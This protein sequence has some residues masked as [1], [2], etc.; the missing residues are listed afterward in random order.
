MPPDYLDT[1][2]PTEFLRLSPPFFV[3]HPNPTHTFMKNTRLPLAVLACLV[4]ASAHAQT[5]VRDFT[6]AGLDFTYVNWD[7]QAT[8]TATGLE[9]AGTATASGGGG[10]GIA[11]TNLSG[12]DLLRIFV[13]TL[14]GNTVP[15]FNVILTSPGNLASGYTFSTSGLNSEYQS[16]TASILAPTFVGF[17]ADG[18]ADLANIT[19]F[20]LQGSFANADAL[21]LGFARIE[22]ASAIPEPSSFASVAAL[23]AL[24]L[25]GARRRSRRALV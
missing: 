23:G 14:P 4:G 11:T 2:L 16:V 20:Q 25:A 24:A 7:G 12:E 8:L 18:P 21:A 22:A 1:T 5:L 3:P 15:T 19:G 6:V 9:I 13:K 10:A 17:G